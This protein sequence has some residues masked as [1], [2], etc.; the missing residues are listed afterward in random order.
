MVSFQ[1]LI[2][3]DVS[4]RKSTKSDISEAF[5]VPE[6]FE[7]IDHIRLKVIPSQAKLLLIVCHGHNF[8]TFDLKNVSK[9]S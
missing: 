1:K 6:M 7:R 3:D 9:K 2:K 4:S 5:L 8:S